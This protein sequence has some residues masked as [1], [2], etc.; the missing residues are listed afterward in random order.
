MDQA[1]VGNREEKKETVAAGEAKESMK[2]MMVS[3]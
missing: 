1:S 3:S 2:L